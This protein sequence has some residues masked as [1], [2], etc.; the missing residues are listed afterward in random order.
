[1]TDLWFCRK[2]SEAALQAEL[3]AI[4]D[5][6]Q[7]IFCRVDDCVESFEKFLSKDRD[8]ARVCSLVAIKGRNLAHGCYSLALDGLGQ[9]SG[10]LL[11]PLLECLE[12]LVYLRVVPDAPNQALENTLPQA[13]KRA[14]IIG[15][16]FKPLRDHLNENAPHLAISSDSMIHL[17][18]LGQGR[19]RITQPFDIRVLEQNLAALFLFVSALAQQCAVSFEWC[20]AGKLPV[21]SESLL[22]KAIRSGDR[23]EAIA[24]PILKKRTLAQ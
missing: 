15:G 9:E 23:G 12:L 17:V 5:A 18:D 4:A 21:V 13:G 6:L 14:A 2:R 1:M 8:A 24:L 19:L 11:R 20:A 22:N 16:K 7:D 10:A 3:S